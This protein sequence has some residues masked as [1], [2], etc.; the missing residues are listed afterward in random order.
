MNPIP[1]PLGIKW[2]L[3]FNPLIDW[4]QGKVKQR[5]RGGYCLENWFA[6]WY[7][8]VFGPKKWINFPFLLFI[9]SKN[10]YFTF[11]KLLTYVEKLYVKFVKNKLYIKYVKIKSYMLFQ[12]I[13][14]SQTVLLQRIQ[15]SVN[16]QLNDKTVFFK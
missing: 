2:P 16:T 7:W 8:K 9:I 5:Q 12:A 3:K 11:S 1:W 14:F 13:Q 4:V 10:Y 6:W 15:F